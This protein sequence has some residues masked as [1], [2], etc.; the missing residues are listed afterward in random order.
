[1]KESCIRVGVGDPNAPRS[2]PH[3]FSY[4]FPP[5]Q[6]SI[7]AKRKN[8]F[9]NSSTSDCVAFVWPIRRRHVHCIDLMRMNANNTMRSSRKPWRK[10]EIWVWP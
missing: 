10:R 6:R 5:D 3:E 8:R 2:A 1:V 7:V 9:K 4:A